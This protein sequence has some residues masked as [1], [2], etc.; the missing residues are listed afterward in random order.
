[1]NRHVARLRSLQRWSHHLRHKPRKK[2]LLPSCEPLE[3]RQLL[4]NVDWISTSSGSWDVGSNWSTGKVPGSG[5]DVVINVSG[6]NPT[7][8]ISSGSQS[9]QSV[10]AD[11]PL[12]ISGGSLTVAAN[13]TISDGLAMTGGSLTAAGSGVTLAVTGATTISGADLFA[14]GGATAS[15]SQLSAYTGP[16]DSEN[17][18]EAAGTGSVLSLPDLTTI[19]EDTTEYGSYT[20]VEALAG[21]SVQLPSLAQIGDGPVVLESEGSGSQLN[22][23]ALTSFQGISGRYEFSTL[24]ATNS[25]TLIGSGLTSLNGVN[26]TLDGTGT[27]ATAQITSFTNA[28]LSLSAGT[29]S[30]PVLADGYNS[31]FKVSG[32]ATVTL[33]DLTD[34]DDTTFLVSGGASVTLPV[35]T[36]YTGPPNGENTLEATGTGSVLSLPDLTT[37]TEDTT[38]Y[39][40][41]T[42]VEALAGG[43]VQLPSLAQIGD[44][45]V[46]LES[47]GSGSQLNVPALTSFQGISGRY[48][49]STLQATNSGTLIGSGLTSLNGVNLTLDGTGTIATA[50][51]TS[52]TN[53]TL[54]LSAGTVSL[55][56]L[57]DGYN[58]SFKVSG[59]AT[60]T[61]PDLSDGDDTTFLVSGGASVT[62]PVLTSYTG[63]ANAGNTLEAT[64]TGSVLSLPD[65]TTI[66]ED[67][68]EYGSYT[69]VEALAGGSVQLPSLAQIGDGPV[70]LESEGSG[71]QLNVP[72]LTSFQGISGR[73]E[74]STLQATNSGT[75]IGSGLTSLNGVNLTLDGTGTIATAQ[76]TSFTNATLSLSA[77]TVSLPVLADGYNSSFKVSGGATVT[78][79]DLTDGDDT[80]FLVSGGASVTLPVL[81][82]YTGPPN[83]ENT[84]EATGTGS[85]LSL[86]DLTTITED[87]TEYGSY[88][89]VEALAG[90]SVQLPSLAQIGDGPV[91]LESEGSGSQLNVPALTSFQGISGRYEFSTLQATN[92]GTLIGSGL[93]SLNGVNLTLDGT[94]TIATAQITSFTNATLSLSAGTVSLPV[95]ADGYNSSF[96]VSGA[97]TV[98]LPDLSD[99][100][101][102]TFLVS[103]GASVTLPVLTSYTGPANAG[104]TLEATGTGSVL[105]LPDLTTITEDTTQYG[106]YTN[107]EA[108]SGGSVQLPSLAQ[109]G[110]GPVVLESEGSGSQ[111]NVPALTSFQGTSGRDEFSTLQA[112]TSGTVIGSGLTS[113]NDVNLTL[114]GTGTIATAQITSFTA[115]TLSLTGG[116]LSLPGLTDADAASILV[117][118]GASLKMPALTQLNGASF[119]IGTGGT[120][121]VGTAVVSMPSAGTDATI[122]VPQL[123]P[124]VTVNL[125]SSG[126][127][128]GPTT[129]NVAQGDSVN[130]TSGTYTGGVAFNVAQGATI[131]LTGGQ[132]VTYSGTLSSS[133]SGAVQ[134]S[135]GTFVVGIGGATLNF[136]A[137]TF[138]WTGGEVD[139]AGGA[140]TNRGT[141]N[142]A[143]PNEKQ[144]Y[145]DGTIDNYGTIIQTGTGDFGLHSNNQSPTTLMNEPGGLYLLES[146]AG[147]DNQGLGD[148]VIDNLG[149]IRK[150]AGTGTSALL[151]PEE[152]FLINTGTIEADS[153]TLYLDATTINQLSSG[154]LAAGTWNALNGSTLEFPSGTSIS[155]SQAN[156]TLGGAGA[157]ITPLSGLASNSGSLSLADGASFATTGDFGNTESLTI[158]AGST[159]TVNG[160]YTQ[161]ASAS[162]TIGIGGTSSGNDYGQLNVTGTATLAGCRERLD[163]QRF[164]AHCRREL[165][166]RY[167]RQRNRRK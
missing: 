157:A 100:D 2:L 104:N 10:T 63:P 77:G 36:S 5:D 114:D 40:S 81:T 71:S 25:G 137:S 154:T 4:S 74:F 7:V 79:P 140:L 161:G 116:S 75:L 8:T 58:S 101:D 78:L 22:V 167:V 39:G 34:G 62:L 37:I 46:V 9:V 164:H 113:L 86:P 1:M 99:G 56:V 109:I 30:L 32:G 147:I 88:T 126:T 82:S 27:I 38:E 68:T 112:T 159:L 162:L 127:F 80:T 165:S 152:G 26:L 73:Y 35:L 166:D 131:D 59:A 41:Y 103:G 87:T 89:N 111:L 31:S 153:G 24:Q 67:T 158:G 66:T 91:V 118:G 149:I 141:V 47:E 143:G 130:V 28:T 146:D 53:A 45:P 134:F 132:T 84:L 72:A 54:S 144:I 142:L 129:F 12:S 108:L 55:P 44:G 49:F 98:T 85:V 121:E 122:N 52:F 151:V 110:D 139:G 11:D 65:L 117:S 70:V 21:G 138:Q 61:L 15:L 133:G 115:A 106:S 3:L 60:V 160:S 94:G 13:S 163:C 150:T 83:G 64:G 16:V 20:N 120:L 105:S 92:S 102:T 93:T 97:A 136:L 23:P 135:G 125:G 51:I 6:A 119:T 95:L 14:E 48:E 107:V 90:G 42:N 43:S 57:A 69:N 148:N 29:V 123:A 33:P 155:T 18:L 128:T 156:I 17:T 145:A 96:K 50:Q 124:G 76:I 19:T